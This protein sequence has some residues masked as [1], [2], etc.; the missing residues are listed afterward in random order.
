VAEILVLDAPLLNHSSRADNIDLLGNYLQD[1]E[2]WT[3][4]FV[5]D[6]LRA[7][8]ATY[9]ELRSA[10]GASWLHVEPLDTPAALMSYSAW[11]RRVGVSGKRHRGEASV[12]CCAEMLQGIAIT[13]DWYTNRVANSNGVEAHGSLWLMARLVQKGAIGVGAAENYVE[14]LVVNG[15]RLPCRGIEFSTWCARNGIPLR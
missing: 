10:I 7:G 1:F 14:A 9:P 8:L 12:F 15:L 2:C 5:I 4:E 13:D 3:T 11:S 6:E